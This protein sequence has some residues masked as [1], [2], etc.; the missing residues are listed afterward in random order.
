MYARAVEQFCDALI[1]RRSDQPEQRTSVTREAGKTAMKKFENKFLSPS[2]Q[3][4]TRRASDVVEAYFYGWTLA[5]LMLG[6]LLGAGLVTAVR[7]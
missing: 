4:L 6:A 3:P 2:V 5:C 7:R 1:G